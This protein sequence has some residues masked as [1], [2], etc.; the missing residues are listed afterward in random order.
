MDR[1]N[2]G[3]T[4]RAGFAG[5]ALLLAAAAA[6]FFLAGRGDS[7]RPARAPVASRTTAAPQESADP[8]A[9]VPTDEGRP[10][11]ESSPVI[12]G[13]VVQLGGGPAAGAAVV[14]FPGGGRR[15]TY[16]SPESGQAVDPIL[17][18]DLFR[19]DERETAAAVPAVLVP[20]PMAAA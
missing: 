5:L 4:F 3:R 15:P 12:R 20:T 18:R 11:A 1:G 7:P 9:P 19:L 2:R 14:L 6:W 16:R 8:R 17:L 10:P 13:R